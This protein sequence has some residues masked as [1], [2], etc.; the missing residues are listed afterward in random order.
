MLLA[1]VLLYCYLIVEAAE[2]GQDGL[3]NRFQYQSPS[4]PRT[5]SAAAT[6]ACVSDCTL[7]PSHSPLDVTLCAT[8]GNTYT[9]KWSEDV[10]L[11]FW[12]CGLTALYA[13]SCGCPNACNAELGLGTCQSEKCECNEGWT[14]VDCSVP[15]CE[16]DLSCG[17]RARGACKTDGSTNYC[18]CSAGY[19][20]KFLIFFHFLL[21]FLYRNI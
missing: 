20:G 14:G 3:P 4:Q 17:G 10:D 18:V 19:S 1:L 9:F 15:D 7:P 13:G 6:E 21:H 2:K 5:L 8:N 16:S 12:R 11:C